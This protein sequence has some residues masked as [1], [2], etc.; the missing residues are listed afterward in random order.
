MPPENIRKPE[1]FWCLQGVQKGT[2]GIK[3]VKDVWKQY[4]YYT[5][6]QQYFD[7]VIKSVKID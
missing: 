2:Y 4:K 1:V 7:D 3:W 6:H 5:W